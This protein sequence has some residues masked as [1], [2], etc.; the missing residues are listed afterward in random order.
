MNVLVVPFAE[1][2][3]YRDFL[4]RIFTRRLGPTPAIAIAS[5]LFAIAHLDV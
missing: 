2:R 4:Q 1:E 5:P 3:V